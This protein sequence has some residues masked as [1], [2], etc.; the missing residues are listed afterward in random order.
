MGARIEI[1]VEEHEALKNRIK[2]LE[3]T[4]AKQDSKIEELSSFNERYKDSIEYF[5]D[6][7]FFERCFQWKSILN[8]V[9]EYIK[10]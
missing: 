5:F 8:A 7:S 4:I 3:Q 10:I 2:E 9:N 6:S 1:S